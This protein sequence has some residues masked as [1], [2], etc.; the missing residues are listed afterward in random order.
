MLDRR[1]A[2][3]LGAAALLI[4][5]AGAAPAEAQTW[6]TLTSSRQLSGSEPVSVNVEYG[7]GELALR[8]ADGSLLYQMDLRYDEEHFSP[9][10]EFDATRRVLRLGAKG[11]DTRGMNVKEGSRATIS[12]NRSVPLDLSLTFGAGEAMLDLG[13]LHLR[14]VDLSTGAS[15]TTVRFGS[16]NVTRAERLEIK[17]GAAALTVL[18]LGNSRA[19]EISFQ[20][21]VGSTTLD[22]SGRWSA[23]ATARVQMGV[24]SVKLRFP[25]SL[26][27]RVSNSSFLTSFDADG[28]VKR[29]S[30]YYSR[31]WD[32]AA[33]KLTVHVEAAFGSV[34]VEWTDS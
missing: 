6:R 15:E 22:F 12:L 28:L 9:V 29:G 26:G 30:S 5:S 10:T 4:I 2:M 24:G 21:G 18:G 17:S 16:P 27:V 20:G 19:E 8:P 11:R 7:A 1:R 3:R 14:R 33:H 34:D 32:S 13:G 23:D 25:R 31:N